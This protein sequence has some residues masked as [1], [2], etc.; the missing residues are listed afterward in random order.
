MTLTLNHRIA[1]A[2]TAFG[3]IVCS[4]G[5]LTA[6]VEV[7]STLTPE[8]YVN[9]VL[10][11]TGVEATNVVFTG[12]PVQI[13][14]ITGFDPA[15][16][17]IE[18]GLILSTEVANNPANVDDG[19]VDEFIDDNLEVSGD[20]DLLTI[21]NSVPPLIG[22]NFSVGS[23]NDVCAIEFDFVA[24]GDT[25]RFNYVFGSDEYLAWINS[26][27][28]DIFGFFLSGPGIN[29]P[30]TDNAI[31]LAEVPGSDPQ[32]AITI[33]SVNNVTNAAYY[34]DNPGNDV[35]CQNGYTVKLTAESEV[36]CGETYHIRLAIADGSDTALES[37]VILESGSFESNSV[38]EVDL[39][40][41]VGGPDANIIT[42]T[43]VKRC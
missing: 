22:Q 5:S 11:G 36:E 26:Q 19:C 38:V 15:E 23:V 1:S 17:P 7:N 24:T 39:S 6:Q 25:I 13:G 18:A 2:C 29:G 10:L 40:I 14:E 33:S 28:N 43:V 34:V 4:M 9:D 16:F 37:I 20:N 32:L 35:L 42:R 3:L 31:N 27:Y 21:A 41:D 8:Q 30:Y 12:S